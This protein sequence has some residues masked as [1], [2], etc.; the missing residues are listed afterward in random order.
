MFEGRGH[1]SYCHYDFP[2]SIAIMKTIKILLS[3]FP[4]NYTNF[5]LLRVPFRKR[6]IKNLIAVVQALDQEFQ[7]VKKNE[8]ELLNFQYNSETPLAL[9]HI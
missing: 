7:A 9:F 5:F 4:Y 8:K 6:K 2:P 3:N 1:S